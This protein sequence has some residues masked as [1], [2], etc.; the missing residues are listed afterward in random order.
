[1]KIIK[2]LLNKL[3]SIYIMLIYFLLNNFVLSAKIRAKFI[4]ILHPKLQLA[5]NVKLRRNVTLYAGGNI[6]GKL[7][8]DA[9][10]FINEEVLLDFSGEIEIGK[11]VG[12]A[13]RSLILSSTHKI[14]HPKRAGIPKKKKTT[15]KDNVWIGAG[16]IIYPGVTVG[17]GA[18]IAAGENVYDNVPSNK[19]LKNGQLTNIVVKKENK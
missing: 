12:L 10:S 17:E 13:M 4:G 7:T 6:T 8:V 14:G 16:A 15:I 18:V 3:L 2:F 19:L 1:M 9:G 11:D 5:N